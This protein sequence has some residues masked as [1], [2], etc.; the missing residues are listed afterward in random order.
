M[1]D[2]VDVNVTL[3]GEGLDI[4]QLDGNARQLR[5]ELLDLDVDH[6]T[7]VSGGPAP[8]DTRG[9]G[10]ELVGQLVVGV[11]PGLVAL[12]QLLDT[13]RG[14]RSNQSHLAITV[15]IGEDRLELTDASAETEKQLVTAF[16]ERHAGG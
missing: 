16:I 15:Q 2:V 13:L 14:W 3:F 8:A 7:P 1:S 12:R 4:D 6:V 5:S 10:A 11:G 9:I